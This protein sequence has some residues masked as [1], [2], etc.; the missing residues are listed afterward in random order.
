MATSD[1]HNVLDSEWAYVV[2]LLPADLDKLASTTG[3][4]QRRRSIASAQ[5]LLRFALAYAAADWSFRHTA[6]MASFM[7]GERI[8]D[9]ALLQ[10]LRKAPAFLRAVISAVLARR[11]DSVPR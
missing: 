4:I 11:L 6:A 9:V 8:S 5:Q 10:R 1:L 2:G 3:A 7:G